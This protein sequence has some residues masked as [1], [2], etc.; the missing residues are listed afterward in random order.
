MNMAG[1]LIRHGRIRTTETK[2]KELRP[3]VERLVTRARV[4]NLQNRR[5]VRTTL[6]MH[7]KA[8]SREV[9]DKT[10]VEKLFEEVAP[11]FVDRPG[12]YT[13]IVKL[14]SRPGDAAPMAFIEWVDF[15]PEARDD[16]AAHAHSHD[17]ATEA[18]AE[19]HSHA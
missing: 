3:F 7:D 15:V 11:R 4:D 2:A 16:S 1:A 17:F 18:E 5:V 6:R 10:I 13:R 9:G 14:G 12:G 8:S 19:A